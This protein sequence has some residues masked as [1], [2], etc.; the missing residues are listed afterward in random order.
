MA[1]VAMAHTA[2]AYIARAYIVVVLYINGMWHDE[3]EHR[4]ELVVGHLIRFVRPSYR[5]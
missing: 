4:L 3:P 1:E 2:M 5:P